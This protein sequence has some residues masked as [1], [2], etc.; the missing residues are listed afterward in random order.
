MKEDG[1]GVMGNGMKNML[2]VMSGAYTIP[3]IDKLFPAE[4]KVSDMEDIYSALAALE[5]TGRQEE[6]MRMIRGLFGIAGK[7]YPYLIA[8]LEK[9]KEM[10]AF[11]ISEFISDFY[12]MVDE[13]KSDEG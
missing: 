2:N 1:N 12:E 5:E 9:Q 13:R 3:L 4:S 11:F 10:Q 8:A 6:A 7:E